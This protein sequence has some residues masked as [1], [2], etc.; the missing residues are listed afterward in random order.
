MVVALSSFRLPRTS[1]PAPGLSSKGSGPQSHIVIDDSS[2]IWEDGSRDVDGVLTQVKDW[3]PRTRTSTSFLMK[4]A[5]ATTRRRRRTPPEDTGVWAK[6]LR[7]QANGGC[8]AKVA[9]HRKLRR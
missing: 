8:G 1:Q 4:E 2:I 9:M 6:V 7:S 5:M 3:M